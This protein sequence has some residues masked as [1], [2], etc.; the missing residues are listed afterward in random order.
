MN[1]FVNALFSLS[2]GIGAVIG[3]VRFRRADPAFLPFL[4]LTWVGFANELIS[5][6][7]TYTRGSNVLNYNLF[8]LAEATLLLW[9]FRRWGLFRRPWIYYLF[10]S[11]A[12][13]G[14]LIDNLLF[15]TPFTFNS[16]FI[17]ASSAAIVIMSITAFNQV[18]VQSYGPYLKNATLLICTGLIIYFTYSTLVEAFTIYGISRTH[19]FR[20]QIYAILAWI[21]LFTN[22]LFALAILWIPP[23]FHYLMQS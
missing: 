3:W 5:L 18:L 15:S 4:C 13:S 10:Q 9:Q 17:I 19:Y 22:L 23:K 16:R 14:W 6:I 8:T 11:A 1:F 20:A 7:A 2:I 12:V 21:N